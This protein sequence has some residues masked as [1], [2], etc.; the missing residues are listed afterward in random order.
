[1]TDD[2]AQALPAAAPASSLAPE[3]LAKKHEIEASMADP[4]GAYHQD[5]AVR[6]RLTDLIRAELVGAKEPVGPDF[7][8]GIDPPPLHPGGYDFS[9]LPI[10]SGDARSAADS[11]AAVAH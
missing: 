5:S 9:G 1:M 10:Y 6:G 2:L 4:A 8:P 11:F 3:M 7:D